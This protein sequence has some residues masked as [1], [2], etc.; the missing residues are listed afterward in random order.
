MC[1]WPRGY[2]WCVRINLDEKFRLWK[3][4]NLEE[5]FR[6]VSETFGV[7]IRGRINM[8]LRADFQFFKLEDWRGS[9]EGFTGFYLSTDVERV[10]LLLFFNLW[11]IFYFYFIF[12]IFIFY[13]YFYLNF[14]TIWDSK[15]NLPGRLTDF[16]FRGG[17]KFGRTKCRTTDTSEFWNFEY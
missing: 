16:R 1:H 13:F 10:I 7:F 11:D 5:Y 6:F 14:F 9:S 8:K 3:S 12:I 2:L 17:V 15:G 4:R